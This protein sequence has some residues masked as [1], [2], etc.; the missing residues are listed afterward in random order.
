MIDFSN[1]SLVREASDP[2][3]NLQCKGPPYEIGVFLTN[4]ILFGKT[5]QLYGVKSVL[6][7]TYNWEKSVFFS[8][9]VRVFAEIYANTWQGGPPPPV[10]IG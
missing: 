1:F 3:C 6:L 7:Q 4:F 8:A 5:R 10:L 9:L 2:V